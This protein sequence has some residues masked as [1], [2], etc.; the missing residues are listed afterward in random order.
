MAPTTRDR[1]VAIAEAMNY[2]A[3]PAASRLAAGRTRTVAIAVPNLSGWYFSQVVG[4]AEAVLS[5]SGYDLLVMGVSGPDARSRFLQDALEL[6]RRVDGLIIVDIRVSTDEAIRLARADVAVVSIGFECEG[7]SSVMLD[8]VGVGERA[9]DHLL[10]LGHES[11]GLVA[12]LPEDPLR[13]AVPNRR[14][15]GFE[16]ALAA[17]GLHVDPAAIVSGNFSVEGGAEAMAELLKLPEPPTAVFAM[18]DEMAMGAIRTARDHGLR[19]PDDLS[20]I[21]V[22]DHDLAAVM[23][24]TT[25]RQDVAGNGAIAARWIVDALEA[26]DREVRRVVPT[27]RLVERSSTAPPAGRN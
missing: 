9:T 12:G 24:L 1:V 3:D 17:A 25:V 20:V 10:G 5:E 13:F 22:D 4:G 14:R 16:T 7:I 8:D 6:H 21:G 11:L 15:E 27:T 23:D 2:R 18:S 19:V 26:D